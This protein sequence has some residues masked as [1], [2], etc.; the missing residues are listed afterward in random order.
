MPVKRK[1]ITQN[2]DIIKTN[3]LAQLRIKELEEKVLQLE[4]ERAEQTL[5]LIRIRA[6][7]DRVERASKS[8]VRGWQLVGAGLA[9][10][11]AIEGLHIAEHCS[12]RGEGLEGRETAQVKPSTRIILDPHSLPGGVSRSVAR[13]P[14]AQLV[15]VAEE[16]SRDMAGEDTC[17]ADGTGAADDTVEATEVSAAPQETTLA[18]SHA[19]AERPSSTPRSLWM[20]DEL[21]VA[22]TSFQSVR[23]QTQA[24]LHRAASID[25][26]SSFADDEEV[27]LSDD[28]DEC[29]EDCLSTILCEERNLPDEQNT[30][31]TNRKRRAP[32][33][34][35]GGSDGGTSAVS[36]KRSA[37]RSS[38][39]SDSPP[40]ARSSRR[41]SARDRKSINYALPKLN[42][43]MRKPDPI[44]LIPAQEGEVRRTE[45]GT[46]GEDSEGNSSRETTPKRT[47][48]GGHEVASTGSLRE[49]RR[50]HQSARMTEEDGR[51]GPMTRR[52]SSNG[53]QPPQH[54]APLSQPS[55]PTD[56][57]R[58]TL[59]G[60]G[61]K[62]L[63]PS[64]KANNVARQGP[65]LSNEV[66]R[67]SLHAAMTLDEEEPRSAPAL[68]QQ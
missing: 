14:E 66:K 1:H 35:V 44:D 37:S 12:E 61:V 67:S 63:A 17:E 55:F 60:A 53:Q 6:D 64:A 51:Q 49:I 59:N 65:V 54:K 57:K 58:T 48:K 34:S 39:E 47:L 29:E 22:G 20:S 25:S 18:R 27:Q 62:V 50:Q 43:K 3:A 15:D 4:G 38:S 8:L 30:S 46:R 33:A 16:D 40:T 21:D 5:E 28:M 9:T 45:G 42:T 68:T 26:L 19:D 36:M 2:R 52:R 11:T 10:M 56:G 31:M 7:M 13:P 32:T 23:K 24:D 41:S